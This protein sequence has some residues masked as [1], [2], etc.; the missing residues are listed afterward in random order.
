MVAD[1]G[2]S[3]GALK[4]L[5]GSGKGM[6]VVTTK[7]AIGRSRFWCSINR[8]HCRRRTPRN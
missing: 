1:E 3:N 2:K 5:G 6:T 8:A 4:Q 7:A